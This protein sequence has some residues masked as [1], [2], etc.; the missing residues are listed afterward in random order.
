[1]KKIILA[2]LFTIIFSSLAVASERLPPDPNHLE[3]G[4]WNYFEENQGQSEVQ[5]KISVFEDSIKKLVD[6]LN[7]PN[8]DKAELSLEKM[9][10]NL[11]SYLTAIE[12][13]DPVATP[14]SPIAHTYSLEHTLE[15][16]RAIKKCELDLCAYQDERVEKQ[17]QITSAQ[18][19]LDRLSISYAKAPERSEEKLN[20]ALEV[21]SYQAAYESAKRNYAHLNSLIEQDTKQLQA[22]KEEVKQA[23]ERIVVNHLD[24][25]KMAHAVADSERYWNNEKKLL[26]EK[27]KE[28]FSYSQLDESDLAEVTHQ[29]HN[30]ELLQHQIREAYA[31]NQMIH[32]KIIFSLARVIDEPKTADP[33]TLRTLAADWLRD[34]KEQKEKA[35]EWNDLIRKLFLRYTQIVT[36]GNI[37]AKNSEEVA[38]LQ[39]DV[40]QSARTN[41][42]MLQRLG[43]TL[44]D[45]TFLLDE[46]DHRVTHLMGSKERYLLDIMDFSSKSLEGA[47][48]W[49]NKPL[50]HINDKP[51]TTFSLIKFFSILLLAIWFSR[52]VANALTRFSLTRQGIHKSLVYKITRLVKYLILTSGLL[53]ALSAVGF[54]F[55]NLLLVAGAL[56]VGLGF[57]LQSIFNNFVSGLIILFESHLRV[58]DIIELS[59]IKGE[60]REI[61][62][63]STIVTTGEGS[64]IIIPNS[65]I[66]T[67]K[68]V[69][70][71]M[72][73]SYRKLHLPFSVANGSNKELVA[74]VVE[75]AASKLKSNVQQAGVTAPKVSLIRFGENGMDFE[76]TV[77]FDQRFGS[78]RGATS[79]YLWAI[80]DALSENNI[81]RATAEMDVRLHS[82]DKP[83]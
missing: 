22:L 77:W 67:T 71:T 51:V 8:R 40:I 46:V 21:V 66:I 79:D 25:K 29:K 55:S 50:V 10:T 2:V 28:H 33:G 38:V 11:H 56:G 17:K 18:D 3:P 5:E 20:L 34:T 7:G 32:A 54:D 74:K 52:I 59:G 37:G 83:S 69:N 31:R 42:M 44:D 65:E 26:E 63:R 80:D 68:V 72:N 76:L 4:W 19:N 16:Y 47:I 43:N 45:S 9:H 70:W 12:L 57:G 81:E 53:I 13:K 62:V 35:D 24:L 48:E 82:K 30:Q 6:Q 27:E 41:F 60:I 49:L 78:T 61:N 1:M 15:I 58:G 23:I 14:V 73:D 36:M 64:E 39:K 75:E